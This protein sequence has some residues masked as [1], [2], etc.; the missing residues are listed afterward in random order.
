MVLV[1]E[2]S[3]GVLKVKPTL[4]IDTNCRQMLKLTCPQNSVTG[5]AG[6]LAVLGYHCDV[7]LTGALQARDGTR[8][9]GRGARFKVA[10]GAHYCQ[11]VG[12]S[13]TG[14]IPGGLQRGA[15]A[16][17][18]C[19]QT[20]RGARR[21]WKTSQSSEAPSLQGVARPSSPS[22]PVVTVCGWL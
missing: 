16:A 10:V 11:P 19:L 15:P 22:L 1:L 6:A 5:R 3:H 7:V 12:G 9:V 2:A 18:H 4:H 14:G 17:R 13:T 21:W 20:L 8:A